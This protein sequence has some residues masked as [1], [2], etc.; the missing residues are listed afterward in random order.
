M[1]KRSL[2]IITTYALALSAVLGVYSF[3]SS[4]RLEAYRTSS[5]YSSML[6]FEETVGAVDRMSR[7]LST[8]VY[9]T[10]GSMCGKICSQVYADAMAA[11]A[12]L[13]TLPFATQELE[14]ISAYL[15]QMGDYAYTLCSQAAQNG[16]DKENIEK[17]E[18]LS[19]VA[20]GLSESL[21][22]LQ[23][24]VHQGSVLL[25]SR[26]RDIVNVGV[27]ESLSYVSEE[28]A[29][30]EADFPHRSSLRYDG[31]YGSVENERV[32][33]GL[34]DAQ[35]LAS[36]A[37]FAGVSPGEMKVC[38]EYQGNQGR[39]C[40]SVGQTLLCVDSSGVE[41]MS[42]TR[43]VSDSRLS[44]EKARQIAHSFLE[45]Q[46]FEELSLVT[47]GKE[48]SIARFSFAPR[49]DDALMSDRCLSISVALDDGS[50]Y[51]FERGNYSKER[52]NVQWNISQ[53]QAVETLP[54]S[55]E[56]VDSSKEI[57]L[58]EGGRDVACYKLNCSNS[59]GEAVSIYVDAST[60]RQR[61]ITV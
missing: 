28:F 13:S 58:S 54:D 26:E 52:V 41:S 9:A 10:D 61:R 31:K 57:L 59:R 8:G 17:L 12:A 53:Q 23:G 21:R 7:T 42:Q 49:Q 35:T 37:R 16:F 19:R 51:S 20:Q 14:E 27:D 40:Y 15:N 4:R 38:H 33:N 2:T 43:L 44:L 18:E 6:A 24:K 34:S 22:E 1:S 47:E 50:I 46:G 29:R 55:L 11:E 36:A 48:G 30:F 32:E 5:K 39:K 60:G 3:V 45:R 25:D 56:L